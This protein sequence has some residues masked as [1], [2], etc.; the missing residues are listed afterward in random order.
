MSGVYSFRAGP[1]YRGATREE[2]LDAAL[3]QPFSLAGNIWEQAKGGVLSSYGLGTAIKDFTVPEGEPTAGEQ[4]GN[5]IRLANPMTAPYEVARRTAQAFMDQGEALDEDGYKASP[6]YREGIPWDAGMTDERAA[7]LAM[8]D[9]AKKVREFYASKRPISSFIGNLAG[10]AVDPI[11]YIPVA[12]PAVKAAAVARLGKIGGAALH[13]AVDAAANTALFGIGTRERRGRYGDDVSWQATVSQIATAA[14]IGAA[15]GTLGGAWEARSA[16]KGRAAIEERLATLKTTQEARVALNEAIDGLARGED[17]RLSPN[18]TEPLSRVAET[19][20]TA[21]A[22]QTMEPSFSVVTPTGV[23]VDVKP[24]IIDALQLQKASGDLQPRDR[25]RAASDA[26]I[27]EMA[28]A[29]DPQ[30]LL[31]SAEADRGAPV[32]GPDNVVESGNGRVAAL[33]RAATESPERF[34]AY[35]QALRDAGYDV[36]DKGVPVLIA[37][38]ISDLTDAERVKFVN[39]ANTSAIARMSATEIAMMDTRAMT[40]ATLGNY[41]PGDVNSAANRAFVGSFLR[42]LPPNE[43]LSLVDAGGK[44]NADG[45]RRIENALIAAA[46]GDADVVARFAEAPDDNVKSIMGAMSDVAGEWA[47]LRREISEG[48]IDASHDVTANLTD[49]LRII[50]RSRQK[51]E[52]DKRPV[53]TVLR[54]EISQGDIFAGDIDPRTKAFV[55]GFYKNDQFTQA[56]GRDIIADYLGNVV[57]ATRE[58]GRPQ[59]FG[60]ATAVSPAEMIENARPQA[61]QAGQARVGSA[62]EGGG[63]DGEEVISLFRDSGASA[64]GARRPLDTSPAAN[65]DPIPESRSEAEARIAQPDNAKALAAQYGVDPNTGAFSEE[66]EITQLATEGRLTENDAAALADAQAT[67]EDGAAYGEALKAAVACLI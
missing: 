15:F 41:V 64:Q 58:L 61:R 66:A 20:P 31:M 49:A 40:G 51:A 43:R 28:A 35:K 13:S 8:M 48:A 55:L 45:I 47:S 32:V 17:V 9:D 19:L 11:N 29:L 52:A 42:N 24:E 3:S 16:T 21:L 7:A 44:L 30:R 2:M 4:V 38:R 53:A 22:R 39:D 63:A 46:Y 1:T 23:R 37:R 67:Y 33:I 36:P 50:S 59:L 6:Y 56:N 54:E 26:Q 65:S 18:A 57:R 14:L 5:A 10:Q 12:G 60:Q 27:A 25:S 62:R 34:A